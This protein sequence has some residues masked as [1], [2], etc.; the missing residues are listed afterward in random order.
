MDGCKGGWLIVA[1][2]TFRFREASA[3]IAVSLETTEGM[4]MTVIDMPIG[5]TATQ[6]EPRWT[7]AAA[8]AFLRA[9]NAEGH[10]SPGSRVFP[11]PSRAALRLYRAGHGYH[12]LNRGLDG[13]KLSQQAYHI[14]GKIDA[15]DLWMTPDRQKQAREGH[16][17]VAFAA[18]TGRTLPPKKSREGAVARDAA[19]SELGF[20]LAAL[21][22]S[23]GPRNRRWGMDD[24]RDACVLA[25]V[26]ARVLSGEH[27]TLPD[28][29]GT[30]ARGLQMEIVA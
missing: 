22:A 6:A 21:A 8:R 20:D 9:R 23:L 14:T 12:A 15:L 17:E 26:A 1:G 2:P 27:V 24:L 25:W 30:D 18:L 11:P 5:L 28:D 3:H 13:P 19:L 16:P 10:A 7:D 29:P 4:A